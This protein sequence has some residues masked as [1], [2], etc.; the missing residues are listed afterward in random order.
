[1]PHIVYVIRGK[2]FSSE[3]EKLLQLNNMILIDLGQKFIYMKYN[4][5]PLEKLTPHRYNIP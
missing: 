2:F 3:M 4:K 1:M 5:F